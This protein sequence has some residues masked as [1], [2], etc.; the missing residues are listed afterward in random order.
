MNL[1]QGEQERDFDAETNNHNAH[2]HVNNEVFERLTHTQIHNLT[3][4]ECKCDFDA[5]PSNHNVHTCE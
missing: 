5:E 2:H 3:E 1:K 4:R